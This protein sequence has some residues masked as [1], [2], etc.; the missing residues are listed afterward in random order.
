MWCVRVAGSRSRLGRSGILAMTIAI[1]PSTRARSIAGVIVALVGVLV[2]LL[3]VVADRPKLR[4]GVGSRST[5]G[6]RM[7]RRPA[8]FGGRLGRPGSR[9]AGRAPGLTGAPRS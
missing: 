7:I 5:S 9:C 3:A 8:C 1:A 2:R 6:L 4:S